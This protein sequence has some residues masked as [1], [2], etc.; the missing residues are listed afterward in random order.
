MVIDR[1]RTSN[2]VK[3]DYYYAKIFWFSIAQAGTDPE[4]FQRGSWGGKF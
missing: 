3:Q 2:D 4:I 1:D